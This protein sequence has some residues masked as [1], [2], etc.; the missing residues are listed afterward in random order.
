MACLWQKQSGIWCITYRENGKQRVR[1]LRTK[2]KREA[3]KLQREIESLL[4][5]DRPVEV[6]VKEKPKTRP[7]NPTMDEFWEDFLPWAKAHRA[8]NTVEEYENW[9]TQFREFTGIERLGDASRVDV[10]E[11]KAK[12][13][14]QGKCKP[15]G[16]GLGKVSVNNALKTLKSIWNHARKLELYS[17]ENPFMKVEAFK[18]PQSLDREYLTGGEIDALLEAC[19][20]YA[21]EKFVRRV[22]ARNVKIAIA[23]MALA[24][25]RKREVCFARWE[26]VQWDQKVL[27]VSSHDEFTTKNKRS[28][29]ISMHSQLIQ[30]I[31]SHRKDKGYMLEALRK[32]NGKAEYRADFKKAFTRVCELAGVKA[33][34]H[35][36]RHSF[37]SR[38]AVRG[39]S[40]H[41][42][43]RWLG[44]ST[45]WITERYAHFQHS[46]MADV[47]DM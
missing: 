24:G 28:R 7:R 1:S 2:S 8:A 18:L 20:R 37:A 35:D 12:L 34:P 41:V 46:Y 6:A 3:L 30:I 32:S 31:K 5:E 25:L 19:D 26:W 4:T 9:F 42:I 21:K 13:R 22:E 14:R 39:R 40:L 23:L 27:M 43:A 15:N 45:T 29:T 16:V 44:H 47:N 17:G 10:E 11:F 33:K 36:L 38:H